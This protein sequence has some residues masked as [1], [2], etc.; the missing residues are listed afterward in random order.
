MTEGSAL[1]E[2]T[3]DAIVIGA[4][5][6]GLSAGSYLATNGRR[7]LVLEQYDTVGG[8][9]VVFRRQRKFEFDVGVHYIGDCEKAGV[10]PTLLRGVGLE[11]KISFL[12]LDKDAYSTLQMPGLTFKVPA[13]WD[14][15]LDRLI[16]TFPTEEKGLR[17]C[18]GILRTVGEQIDPFSVP[19]SPAGWIQWGVTKPT[20]LVWALLPLKRLFDVCRLS[21]EARHI[22]AAENGVYAAPPSVAAVGIHACIMNHYLISG[23]YYPKGGGQVIPASLCNVIQTHGGEV[24]TRARVEK[25]LVENGRA[26]G[27]RMRDGEEIFAPVVISNSD[28][29]KTYL[30]LVG[31]EHLSKIRTKRTERVTMALPLFC[32]YLGLD[33]DISTE[34]PNSIL[35]NHPHA[36][37]E[38]LYSAAY[39]ADF[40]DEVIDDLPVF[41]TSGSV[42]DP[43]NPH[44]A[45]PGFST[46]EVM[47]GA[48]PLHEW[49]GIDDAP[50]EGGKYRRVEKYQER[51]EP[52]T[53]ALIAKAERMLPSIKGHI[54]YV[55]SGS[56]LTQERYTLSSGGACYGM[57]FRPLQYGPFRPKASTE[58]DGLY[59]TGANTRWGQ[60]MIGGLL[61][62]CAT[63]SAVLGRDL[64]TEIRS[65]RV[66]GDPSRITA[67]APGWDPLLASQKMS[68]RDLER[69]R[70][71]AMSVPGRTP[72]LLADG[73]LDDDVL[74]DE[75]EA[76]EAV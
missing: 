32:V 37:Q 34:M 15:Y 53:Q 27:V 57:E 51:K 10:I 76:R 7:V 59:L 47:T 75:S 42:K 40:A 66:Y 46:L 31:R 16:E 28:Y 2:Q 30:D 24:R 39:D 70:V 49:W 65:G 44:S 73:V 68:K 5:L 35:W 29:K 9:T 22:I 54:V 62:G 48:T 61:G 60:G 36:D 38:K 64:L 63:A 71:A 69:E 72:H 20:A 17:R 74:D 18:I 67:G 23:A 33:I 43:D 6:G 14:R 41:V 21:P 11:E 8:C 26:R 50:V 3:W 56:P 58:I 12:P 1:R 45:P 55:E 25:I 19:T 4:G 52:L 13:G